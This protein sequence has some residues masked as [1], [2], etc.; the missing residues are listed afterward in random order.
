[1]RIDTPRLD[2]ITLETAASWFQSVLFVVVAFW[3]WAA[4]PRFLRTAERWLK[5]LIF[6]RAAQRLVLPPRRRAPSFP[7]GAPAGFRRVRCKDSPLRLLTRN[8]LPKLRRGGAGERFERLSRVLGELDRFATRLLKR[9]YRGLVASRLVAAA[10][11]ACVFSCG[12]PP[13]LPAAADTS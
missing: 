7:R 6:A 10:P 13:P 1:M 8:A 5:A 9:L 2:H 11:P 4:G 12:A 3:Q